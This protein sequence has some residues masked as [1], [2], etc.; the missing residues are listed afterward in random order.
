MRNKGSKWKYLNQNVIFTVQRTNVLQVFNPESKQ[1]HHNF[2]GSYLFM[3][4]G[5]ETQFL[6]NLEKIE[7]MIQLPQF[8]HF[9]L[10]PTRKL[11]IFCNI[12]KGQQQHFINLILPP[13]ENM[14]QFFDKPRENRNNDSITPILSPIFFSYRGSSAFY[15]IFQKHNNNM[16]LPLFCLLLR[17]RQFL[18]CILVVSIY[19]THHMNKILCCKNWRARLRWYQR[20]TI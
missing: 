11:C 18:L 20:D 7:T 14:A 19:L 1:K 13:L 5:T 2:L 6:T 9:F 12:S 17:N 4:H 16:L 10:F 3:E 8:C 15:V